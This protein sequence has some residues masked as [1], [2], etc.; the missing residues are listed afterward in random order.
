ML[1]KRSLAAAPAGLLFGSVFDLRVKDEVV[2]F[3]DPVAVHTI[4]LG[5]SNV[6]NHSSIAN[7]TI[8]FSDPSVSLSPPANMSELA[9][10][11]SGPVLPGAIQNSSLVHQDINSTIADVLPRPINKSTVSSGDVYL[12]PLPLPSN[13]L[14]VH[15]PFGE[16]RLVSVGNIGYVFAVLWFLHLIGL[17]LF[18]DVPKR[19]ALQG[20][21]P[22]ENQTIMEQSNKDDD[23]DA[24][25][26]SDDNVFATENALVD[27]SRHGDE[28]LDGT[29]E[30]L[31]TMSRR[32]VNC[33]SKRTF[34][35]SIGN[36]WRLVLSNVAFPTTAA[37]LFLAKATMEVLL[38]SSSTILSRYFAWSGAL[39]G[40]FMGAVTSSVLPINVLLSEEKNLVERGVIKVRVMTLGMIICIAFARAILA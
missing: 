24:F 28:T 6:Q 35:E 4:H 34:I 5:A 27:D 9:L 3:L 22:Y 8:P 39:A 26:D 15:L 7:Q 18:Y 17:V 13:S 40:L 1:V 14:Q 33:G 2:H 25:D 23:M 20:G 30:K 19:S 32:S 11:S 16:H 10:N 38:C 31:Q 36:V 29:Y 37:I 21:S 12:P